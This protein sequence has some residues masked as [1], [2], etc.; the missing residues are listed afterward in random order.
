MRLALSSRDRI[1]SRV[2]NMSSSAKTGDLNR[3]HS[4][5]LPVVAAVIL[6]L[7]SFAAVYSFGIVPVTLGVLAFG[8]LCV[9]VANPDFATQI[10]VL[11]MYSNAAAVAVHNN[12]S[13]TP[14]AVAFFVMLFIPAVNFIVFRREG[15]RIDTV[16]WLM[17]LYL[18]IITTSAM[19]SRV[20]A[21]SIKPI[22]KFVF[23]GLIFYVLLINSFRSPQLLRRAMWIM[24][25][26]AGMLGALS[27]HQ[28]ITKS[29]HSNYGG[30]A[31]T[32]LAASE[33]GGASTGDEVDTGEFK[34]G[35]AVGQFRALGPVSDPNFYSQIL[36]A[37]LPFGLIFAFVGRSK[38]IR[39]AAALLCI[40]LM[41]GVVLSFSR[42]A[43]LTVFLLGFS[44]FFLRYLKLRYAFLFV[45]LMIGVLVAMP[46]YMNRVLSV[47]S[48]SS[49]KMEDDSMRQRSGIVRTGVEVF[50]HNPV[51]GV[52]VGQAPNYIEIS[53]MGYSAGKRGLAPHN[54]YL[55]LLVESGILGFTCFMAIV[56]VMIRNL[57]RAG[58]YWLKKRPEYAQL[59]MACMLSVGAYLATS[60]FLHMAFPRYFWLLMGLAGAAA[61]IFDPEEAERHLQRATGVIVAQ[62]QP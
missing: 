37:A 62:S 19:L 31:M 61:R 21:E 53:G 51:L 32:T 45:V 47:G 38:R 58:R 41:A 6:A 26:I 23:E 11:V 36:V 35:V 29:F 49:H 48:V 10:V 5:V 20:P 44:L 30:F 3:P 34:R 50:L 55:E 24:L 14:V 28:S 42:G 17:V 8:G 7:V 1:Q 4:L 60:L 57:L 54:T 15:L 22:S 18:V 43:A 27:W 12:P 16:T 56:I 52:G 59:C 39:V 13:L 33:T 2:T 46:G 25:I 40:P 9:A